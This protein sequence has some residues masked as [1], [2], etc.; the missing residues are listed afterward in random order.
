MRPPRDVGR[1]RAVRAA[2]R[3]REGRRRKRAAWPGPWESR[4]GQ[5]EV[6]AR[7]RARGAGA[8]SADGPEVRRRPAKVRK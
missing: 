2:R 1:L 8:A 3:A 5:G 7:T 6:R 4:P